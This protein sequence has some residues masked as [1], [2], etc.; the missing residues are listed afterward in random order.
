MCQQLGRP[1]PKGDCLSNISNKRNQCPLLRNRE[2]A[3]KN[4][5]PDNHLDIRT[6]YETV[7]LPLSY[8]GTATVDIVCIAAFTVKRDGKRL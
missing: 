5:M 6:D 8:I 7:A 1:L 2:K 4:P 3:A